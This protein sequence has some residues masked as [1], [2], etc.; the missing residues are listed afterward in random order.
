MPMRPNRLCACGKVVASNVICLCVQRRKAEAD[1]RRPTA[2]Q[3]GYGGQ[4]AKARAGYLASHPTCVMVLSTGTCG[5]PATVV[6]H[7]VPHKGNQSLLWD[8][9]N[10]AALCQHCHN[11]IKQ[12]LERNTGPHNGR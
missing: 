3:R 6:D 5:K 10:W 4:W 2:S 12:S 7:V 11:S 1:K 8:K 9:G